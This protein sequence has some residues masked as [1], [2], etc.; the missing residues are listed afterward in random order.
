M[1][2]PNLFASGENKKGTAARKRTEKSGFLKN[3]ICILSFTFLYLVKK[4]QPNSKKKRSLLL[5]K[6][7]ILGKR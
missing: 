2:S 4:L 1:P 7:E 5:P 6:S 3:S